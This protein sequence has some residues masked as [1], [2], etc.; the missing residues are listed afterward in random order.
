[1]KSREDGAIG[2]C[3]L[4]IGVSSGSVLNTAEVRYN[5]CTLNGHISTSTSRIEVKISAL[6]SPWPGDHE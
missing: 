6:E 5:G 2:Y 1:M 4:C 3:V